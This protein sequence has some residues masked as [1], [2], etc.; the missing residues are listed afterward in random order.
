L[1][2]HI[3]EDIYLNEGEQQLLLAEI[4]KISISDTIQNEYECVKCSRLNKVQVKIDDVKEYKD[5]KFPSKFEDTDISIEFVDILNKE[6]LNKEQEKITLAEDYDGVTSPTDIEFAMHIKIPDKTTKEVI[7]FLDEMAIKDL[8]KLVLS[9][10]D[11]LPSCSF[12]TQTKC[13]YCSGEQE[14]NLDITQEIFEEILK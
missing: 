7:S 9:L 2:N 5:N 8:S 11:C 12:V 10:E 6:T 14:I 13:K 4:K 1:Y 3:K